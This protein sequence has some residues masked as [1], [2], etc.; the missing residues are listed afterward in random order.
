MRDPG[1]ARSEVVLCG[2]QMC[3]REGGESVGDGGDQLFGEVKQFGGDTN[4]NSAMA[5]GFLASQGWGE[6]RGNCPCMA[7]DRRVRWGTLIYFS[8]ISRIL[9][10]VV[11]RKLVLNGFQARVI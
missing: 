3:H 7:Q 2:D 9:E 6:P 11:L 8:K 5:G 4:N 1:K 10:K